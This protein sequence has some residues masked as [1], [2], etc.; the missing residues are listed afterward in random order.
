MFFFMAS[1]YLHQADFLDEIYGKYREHISL[2]VGAILLVW[3]LNQKNQRSFP[4]LSPHFYK[5]QAG[6]FDRTQTWKV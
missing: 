2:K 4:M 5:S 6:V 1:S 3:T